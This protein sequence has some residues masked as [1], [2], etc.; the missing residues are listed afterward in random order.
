MSTEAAAEALRRAR[1]SR[2]TFQSPDA[3]AN[4]TSP[5]GPSSRRNQTQQQ[6]SHSTGATQ[7][8]QSTSE[9]ATGPSSNNASEWRPAQSQQEKTSSGKKQSSKRR[10]LTENDLVSSVGIKNLVRE[11]GPS[12]AKKVKA[13]RGT[14]LEDLRTVMS[15]YKL[16]T[17]QLFSG[18]HYEDVMEQVTRLGS[19]TQVKVGFSPPLCQF[20]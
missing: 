11:I 2:Q 5:Q 13:K 18:V 15:G 1:S 17:H 8:H 3:H 14:E 9:A 12:V 20:R 7:Q 19:K 6:G 10:R 16:W 4:P